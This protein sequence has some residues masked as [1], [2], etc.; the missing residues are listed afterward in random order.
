MGLRPFQ[1][2]FVRA[3]ESSKYDRLALS[4]PR[5]NGKSW[6][7]AALCV[8]AMTPGD[9]LFAPG[10][11]SVLL[12][13]SLEQARIVFRFIRRALEDVPDYRFQD[14]AARVGVVHE[15]TGTRIRAL[16]SN[17]R[18]AFGLGADT[19]LAIC[20]EPGCWET[21]GGQ[22]LADAIDT[23]L[24]K[25][26]SHMRVI[27][28]GTVAPALAGGWWP[29]MIK[30]G[31]SG[32]TFVQALQGD[33]ERWDQWPAIRRVNPL[34]SIS[35]SFREKLLE[36]RDAARGDSRLQARFLSYRLNRP[37]ADESKVL[38][39]VA[40]WQAVCA[41]P[42]PARDGRPLVGVDLGGGRAFSAGVAL[43]RSG[44]CEA[45]AIAPGIPSIGA[46]EKRDRVP[47]GAYSA[48][49]TAGVLRVATGRR[50]PRVSD[51]MT[52]VRQWGPETITCDRFRLSELRDCA[53]GVR[54]LPRVSRWSESTED[55]RALRR[56]ALD[57]DLGVDL[58]SRGL[59]TA[60]L[61]AATIL[62]DDAGNCRMIK[63]TNNVSRDDAAAALV[64]A[65]GA[66]ARAPRPARFRHVV[67]GAGA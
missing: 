39:T 54:L 17:G 3:V 13:A 55:I 45:V 35:A 42:V 34:A 38:L 59:L 14:S 4:V 52:L 60:S 19:A 12:A 8:R 6:L 50:V 22:L 33:P 66:L 57:G 29:A 65:A 51:L 18:T 10:C 56:L 43:W 40:D 47:A 26:G 46:Q 23:A 25:V 9:T 30:A 63:R 36:E 21:V 62:N 20:D 48:L 44:R 53:P 58:A 16:G 32:R 28:I 24:G 67:V 15:P 7:A 41:R 1:R 61:A 37:T 64:L 2:L 31:T 27:Y 49:V 11:E 5:G